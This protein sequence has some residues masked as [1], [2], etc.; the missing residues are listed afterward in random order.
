M[1]IIPGLDQFQNRGL[2]REETLRNWR[3]NS[4]FDEACRR[5]ALGKSSV[6]RSCL[7]SWSRC[8]FCPDAARNARTRRHRKP[9]AVAVA[10]QPFLLA[11]TVVHTVADPI[12]SNAPRAIA[13]LATAPIRVAYRS[14]RDRSK[15]VFRGEMVD[16]DEPTNAA[17]QPSIPREVPMAEPAN[18]DQPVRV[19]YIVPRAQR[20]DEPSANRTEEDDQILIKEKI[21]RLSQL[22]GRVAVIDR[23]SPAAARSCEVV[24]PTLRHTLRRA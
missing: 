19:A 14:A 6:R 3:E 13:T 15:E 9:S 21:R 17:E 10:L 2:G 22:R 12:V 5:R 7:L 11:R 24:S 8:C 4:F 23:W 18:Y 20:P 1:G 16:E